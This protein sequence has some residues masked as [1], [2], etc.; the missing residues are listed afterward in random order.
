VLWPAH[1]HQQ[2]EVSIAAIGCFCAL[3]T[4]RAY[5]ALHPQWRLLPDG[6]SKNVLSYHFG[7]NPGTVQRERPLFSQYLLA[8]YIFE[9]SNFHLLNFI[10]RIF[11]FSYYF[12]ANQ[13]MPLGKMRIKILKWIN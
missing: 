10:F 4:L 11:S 1:C 8:I 2:F 12:L 13:S 6:S 9:I 5:R 7:Q 3:H